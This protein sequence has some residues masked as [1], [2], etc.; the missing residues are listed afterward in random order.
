MESINNNEDLVNYYNFNEDGSCISIGTKIGFK[1]ITCNPFS[2]W[3]NRNFGRGIGIVE[4]YHSSN[5]IVL[6][7]CEKNSKFPSNKLII[8][9]DNIKEI[10][11]EIRISSKIRIIKI[12]QDKLFIVNDIKV[13]VL[14]FENLSLIDSFQLYSNKKEL[15]SFS[16][17]KNTQIAYINK[18]YKKIYIKKIELDKEIKI[19][20]KDIELEFNYLQF[21]SKGDILLGACKGRVYLYESSNGEQIR[22]INNDNLKNGNINCC[23]FSQDDKFLAI[24]TIEDNSGRINIF[25]IGTKKETSIFDYFMTSEDKCLAYFKITCKEFIFRFYK[26]EI[27]IIITNNGDFIKI[28]FDKLNGGYCKKKECKKI[29]N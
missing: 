6:S 9:D 11:R 8:W 20:I 15:I 16:V 28:N 26:D 22:E 29:F 10:I 18:N 14:N 21:N 27:I 1:I 7:G 24:S 4:I 5:I 12:I 2:N 17:Y 3:N 25:D 13:Y 23:C 19:K